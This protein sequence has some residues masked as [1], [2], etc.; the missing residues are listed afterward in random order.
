MAAAGGRIQMRPAHAGRQRSTGG[1][2]TSR[3]SRKSATRPLDSAAPTRRRRASSVGRQASGSVAD[4][5]VRHRKA[6]GRACSMQ[7]CNSASICA[8]VARSANAHR[9]GPV[10]PARPRSRTRLAPRHRR[11]AQTFPARSPPRK[12]G[13]NRSTDSRPRSGNNNSPH[14]RP[15]GRILAMGRRS[16]P[17]RSWPPPPPLRRRPT[18]AW[19][20]PRAKRAPQKKAT[21]KKTG[22]LAGARGF[23][24][25]AASQP[26]H[27][28]ALRNIRSHGE[29]PAQ[30][31]GAQLKLAARRVRSGCGIRI[32]ARPSRLLR[33]AMPSGE[34]LGLSG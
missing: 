17:A 1:R 13:G 29:S 31:F 9:D 2:T 27:T 22:A 5:A 24:A 23:V 7:R 10:A 30:S 14:R 25:G 12:T 8:A 26:T 11:C 18:P 33:P 19:P 20:R 4:P 28:R 15:R 3:H 21:R 16:N 34:P 32:V 6:G